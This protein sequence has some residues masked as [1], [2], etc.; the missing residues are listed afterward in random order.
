AP[1]RREPYA[2]HASYSYEEPFFNDQ[3]LLPKVIVALDVI[4]QFRTKPWHITNVSL[5]VRHEQIKKTPRDLIAQELLDKCRGLRLVCDSIGKAQQ[6]CDVRSD[7]RS[8]FV[9]DA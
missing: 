2:D 9:V 6:S 7:S 4:I 3:R 8:N 5:V 1:T